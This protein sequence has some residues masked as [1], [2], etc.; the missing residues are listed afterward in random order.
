MS[1]LL[2]VILSL[3]LASKVAVTTLRCNPF[4]LK[5]CR[6]ASVY[7]APQTPSWVSG[8]EDRGNS[9]DGGSGG[10][11]REGWG[12]ASEGKEPSPGKNGQIDH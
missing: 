7:T 5:K 4:Q 12:K 1:D 10:M 8:R 3:S 2:A 6:N 9:R 11:S